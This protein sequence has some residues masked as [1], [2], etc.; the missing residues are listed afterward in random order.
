M[1]TSEKRTLSFILTSRL[2]QDYFENLFRIIRGKGGFRDNPNAEQ[3]KDTFRRVV[4][5]MLFVQ[6]ISSNCKVESDKILFDI[7]TIYKKPVPNEVK[8]VPA[9]DIAMIIKPPLSLP[10]WN[11]AAYFA[12][13][14]IRKN[15]LMT[16]RTVQINLCHQNYLL[17]IKICLCMSF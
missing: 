8:M 13:Y 12:G 6:S 7:K 1:A 2:N 4:A 17:L 5:H 3:F 15:L 11:V 9:M 16:V 10:E 14:L